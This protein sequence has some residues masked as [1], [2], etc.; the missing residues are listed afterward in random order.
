MNKRVEETNKHNL[1]FHILISAISEKEKIKD[2]KN[3]GVRSL[4]GKAF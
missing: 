1:Y 3:T 2:R 4:S